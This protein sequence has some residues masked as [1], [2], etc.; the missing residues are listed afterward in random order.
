MGLK[1][2]QA[3]FVHGKSEVLFRGGE[4]ALLAVGSM[5]ETACQVRA[6]LLEKG[7]NA[8]VVN[9]RFV[10]TLDT[11]ML[12]DLAV[13]HSLYVTMEE[14]VLRGGFGEAVGRHLNQMEAR[15]D[16]LCIGIP[17]MY[18]EHGNVDILKREVGIDQDGVFEKICRRLRLD[19][20]DR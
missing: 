16:L 20:D 7:I 19:V 12:N 5:V 13:D 15:P 1:T 6:L 17:D 10:K 9:V 11:D 4:V 14:N 3:P 18:V 8:S 2:Y